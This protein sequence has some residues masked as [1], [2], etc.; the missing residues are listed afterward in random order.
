MA[1]RT[2]LTQEDPVLHKPCHQVTAFDGKLAT[3]LQDMRDTLIHSGGVGL[4]APQIGILRRVVLVMDG[5]EHIIELINPKILESS[6]EQDGLEG[7]L[8]I[9]GVHEE[10]KRSDRINVSAQSIDGSAIEMEAE[11][12]LAICIQHECDHLDGILFID[13]LS[14][15]KRKRINKQL[16]KTPES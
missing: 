6:G 1:L 13:H 16:K 12:L 15:L 5:E 2:I 10:V 7:C 8:S 11:D 9:P 14:S 3:L 4:A